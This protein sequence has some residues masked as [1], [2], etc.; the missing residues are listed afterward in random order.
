MLPHN[1]LP[2]WNWFPP[3]TPPGPMAICPVLPR[4]DSGEWEDLG[5]QELE[6]AVNWSRKLKVTLI[7]TQKYFTL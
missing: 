6:G 5:R 7:Y 3:M 2:T 4:P 1:L